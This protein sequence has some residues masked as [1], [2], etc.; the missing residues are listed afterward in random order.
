M[1]NQEKKETLSSNNVSVKVYY[2]KGITLILKNR[3]FHE[4]MVFIWKSPAFKDYDPIK[5]VFISTGK[6]LYMDKQAFMDYLDGKFNQ[7]ALIEFT[8]CDELYRN[9]NDFKADDSNF[10][11]ESGSLWKLQGKKL[12]LIDDDNHVE[13]LISSFFEI[14]V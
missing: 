10:I 4:A 6:T 9:I 2:A 11:V 5:M 14:S 12:T 1:R 3:S 7:Q 8:Q 13:T